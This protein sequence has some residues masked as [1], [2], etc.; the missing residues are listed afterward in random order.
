MGRL[1]QSSLWHLVH[2]T[3]VV[4]LYRAAALD[5]GLAVQP[6]MVSTAPYSSVRVALKTC[7]R[8]RAAHTRPVLQGWNTWNAFHD[9]INETLVKHAADM[10]VESGLQAAGYTYLNI[11]GEY[12]CSLF[13]LA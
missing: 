6:P 2:A 5:N 7:A 3:I 8:H 12:S 10:L 13:L 11:D 4:S 9:E 1:T